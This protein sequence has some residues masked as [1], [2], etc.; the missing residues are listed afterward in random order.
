MHKSMRLLC[1]KD[2]REGGAVLLMIGAADICL[3]TI[4]CRPHPMSGGWFWVGAG[5]LV[6]GIAVCLMGFL[7]AR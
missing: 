6:V 3:A 7:F 2:L 4:L 1:P 5:E